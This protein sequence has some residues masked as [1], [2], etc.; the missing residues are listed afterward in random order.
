MPHTCGACS[1]CCKLLRIKP[2]DKPENKWCTHC[3][4]GKG[5][6]IYE[7]RPEPCRDFVC[8]YIQPGN[9]DIPEA[10]RPDKCKVMFYRKVVTDGSLPS[11][12]GP[13]AFGVIDPMYPD[14]Y[15]KPLVWDVICSHVTAMGELYLICGGKVYRVGREHVGKTPP[16]LIGCGTV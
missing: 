12:A 7:T 6:T 1:M 10:L 16:A 9:E 4:V 14:A 5:C 3:L 13:V 2:L 8:M 15:R 11:S